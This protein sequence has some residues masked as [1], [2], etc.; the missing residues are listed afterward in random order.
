M[1]FNQFWFSQAGIEPQTFGLESSVL[2]NE[3]MGWKDF[4]AKNLGMSTTYAKCIECI[5]SSIGGT[6][7]IYNRLPLTDCCTINIHFD[8]SYFLWLGR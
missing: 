1:F 6:K 8:L 7:G 4:Q 5:F 2:S 3:P